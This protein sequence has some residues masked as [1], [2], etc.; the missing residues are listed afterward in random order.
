MNYEMLIFDIDGT[1]WEAS[2]ITMAA[3]N[4]V[5]QQ[6]P[7]ISKV[8]IEDINKVMGLGK[9]DIARILMPNIELSKAIKYVELQI[10]K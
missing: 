3:A 1:L 9:I 6:Y 4:I 2:E 10:N 8:T 5:A 7:E